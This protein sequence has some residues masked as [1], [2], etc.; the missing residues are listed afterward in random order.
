[1]RDAPP[2]FF[3]L[4]DR[5]YVYAAALGV[6][7]RFLA[8]VTKL[9]DERGIATDQLMGRAL[10]LGARPGDQPQRSEEHTSELQSRGH[11]VCRLLLEKNKIIACSTGSRSRCC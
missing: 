9:A 2:D 3:M 7:K 4:W 10:W 6:A 5:Y 8:N 11:L 1:M